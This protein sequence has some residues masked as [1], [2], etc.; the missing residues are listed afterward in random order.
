V[1][2][3]AGALLGPYC[4]EALIGAGGMGEVYRA[5]DTR[6]GR[7]VAIK[8]LADRVSNERLRQR[9]ER[10]AMAIARFVHPH[11][12]RLYDIGREHDLSFLVMEHLNGDTLARRIASHPMSVDDVVAIIAADIADAVHA[13]HQQGRVHRDL[14]PSNVMLTPDGIKLLDFGLLH[15]IGL[16][17]PA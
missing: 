9:F 13:A 3:L 7:T 4:I 1:T 8:V 15:D 10:E 14:K 11:I 2:L 17:S 5:I 6:L 12:C 16:P